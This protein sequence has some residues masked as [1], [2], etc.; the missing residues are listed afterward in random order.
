MVTPVN[1]EM[2]SKTQSSRHVMFCC[3]TTDTSNVVITLNCANNA[4]W[5]RWTVERCGLGFGPACTVKHYDSLVSWPENVG[6]PVSTA[7]HLGRMQTLMSTYILMIRRSTTRKAVIRDK[8]RTDVLRYLLQL[9]ELET[10]AI[11]ERSVFD[12]RHS[13][14]LPSNSFARPLRP[15]YITHDTASLLRYVT[16]FGLPAEYRSD[17]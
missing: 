3:R 5:L 16:A 11:N 10:Y 13:N 1:H 4:S 15:A 2:F 7:G 8:P 6:R 17:M 9:M 14:S 12:C